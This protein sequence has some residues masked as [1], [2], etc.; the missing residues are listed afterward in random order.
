MQTTPNTLK[1]HKN[2]LLH[3]FII[4]KQFDEITAL[5]VGLFQYLTYCTVALGY[6]TPTVQNTHLEPQ[7]IE[8]SWL[9]AQLPRFMWV[10]SVITIEKYINQNVVKELHNTNPTGILGYYNSQMAKLGNVVFPKQT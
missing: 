5:F 4:I 10:E 1:Y 9:F 7:Y 8:A 3:L 6:S 2:D